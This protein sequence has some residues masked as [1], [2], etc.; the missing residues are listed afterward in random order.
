MPWLEESFAVAVELRAEVR[1]THFKAHILEMFSERATGLGAR[2]REIAGH[3]LWTRRRA[4]LFIG[5]NGLGNGIHL[6]L[7]RGL[8]AKKHVVFERELRYFAQARPLQKANAHGPAA[9][10]RPR[11]RE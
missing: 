11:D 1:H 8:T 6:I 2:F 3:V 4:K 10:F 5:R 9:S 7:E